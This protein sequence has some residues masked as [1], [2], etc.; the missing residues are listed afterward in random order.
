[1]KFMVMVTYTI[2]KFTSQKKI[3]EPGGPVLFKYKCT[4]YKSGSQVDLSHLRAWYFSE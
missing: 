2:K 1:M 3:R 4:G